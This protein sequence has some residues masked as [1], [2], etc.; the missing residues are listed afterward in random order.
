MR[1]LVPL[2]L[3][4]CIAGAQTQLPQAPAPST[5]DAPVPK[6]F[7]IPEFKEAP[8]RIWDKKL[9]FTEAFAG[10]AI[11]FDAYSTVNMHKPCVETNRILGAHPSPGAVAGLFGGQFAGT[12]LISYYAKKHVGN[13]KWAH[14][15]WM[16]PTLYI[17][18]DHLKGGI[19]NYAIGCE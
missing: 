18:A 19:H 4:S 17:G 3:L 6:N 15:L 5:N 10:A 13:R 1:A 14:A 16:A 11:A 12:M 2:L 9:I 7:I 8:N